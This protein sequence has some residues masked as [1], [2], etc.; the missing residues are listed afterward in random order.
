MQGFET[1]RRTAPTQLRVGTDL[2]AVDSVAESLRKFGSRYLQRIYTENEIAYCAT[3]PAEMTRRLAARFAAKEATLKVLR[4]DNFWLDWRSIEVV[5]TAGGWCEIE[6]Q[7]A[8]RQ[9]SEQAGIQSL[10]VS[11][12]HEGGY[13]L[14]VVAATVIG[15]S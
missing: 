12:S 11:L 5:K 1:T 9:L 10:S 15:Q 7:G 14:A 6:L 4:P 3:S 2:I 8:A 13:A